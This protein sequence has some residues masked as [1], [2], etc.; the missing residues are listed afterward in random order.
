L[1]RC[2]QL[3]LNGFGVPLTYGRD[4]SVVFVPFLVELDLAYQYLIEC[5]FVELD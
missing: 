5:G 1:T 3:W 4:G 2:F